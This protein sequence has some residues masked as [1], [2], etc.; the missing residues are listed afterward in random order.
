MQL[1]LEP[2]RQVHI[3]GMF[4]TTYFNTFVTIILKEDLFTHTEYTYSTMHKN[5]ALCHEY[6]YT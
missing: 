1:N 4:I 6:S 2:R 5:I 3:E